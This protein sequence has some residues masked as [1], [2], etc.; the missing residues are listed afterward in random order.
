M[1]TEETTLVVASMSVGKTPRRWVL[2]LSPDTTVVSYHPLSLA[3]WIAK[4]KRTHEF[5]AL[6]GEA[7]MRQSNGTPP[8]V[9]LSCVLNPR[10][11]LAAI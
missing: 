9:D 4:V 10:A 1:A 3:A 7:T 8:L 5:Q 6:W 2:W 11:L